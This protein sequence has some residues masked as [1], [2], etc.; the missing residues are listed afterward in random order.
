MTAP[1]PLP[2]RARDAACF[3]QGR[4]ALPA[5]L[6]VWRRSLGRMPVQ[7]VLVADPGSALATAW[8]RWPQAPV[9]LALTPR[10]A[11]LLDKP[12]SVARIEARLLAQLGADGRTPERTVL[13]V[14]MDW[15]LQAPSAMANGAIWGTVIARLLGAGV[16]SCLSLYH[17]RHLAERDLLAGLHAHASVV[18]ADG[19]VAN[20][21]QLPPGL[22]APGGSAQVARLRLDHWL[23]HLSPTLQP[24]EAVA[25]SAQAA[26][27]SGGEVS[28]ALPGAGDNG[29][30]DGDA[31]A[32]TGERW[33]IR[34]FGSLRVYRRDGQALQWQ[35]STGDG[36]SGA[37]RKLRGL[38]A[39]LLMAGDRG[40]SAAELV[41][42]L[43]PQADAPEKALNR[44]HHTINQLRQVLLPADEADE[45]ARSASTAA[46]PA[47]KARQ[48]PYLLRQDQRYV[49]RTPPNSWIDVEEF[50][51]LCRQGGDLLR[52][53][54]PQEALMCFDSA[55]T[56]Y[57]GD[58]FADLPAA[59]TDGTDADWCASTRVWL[60]ELYFKVHGDCARTQRELGNPLQ[61]AA[62][63]QQMLQQDP[64]S[65]FAHAE[66]MRLHAAQGRRDALERQFQRYRRALAAN[67]QGPGPGEAAPLPLMDLYVALMRD[68]TPVKT[69]RT[70]R[71]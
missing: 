51:Q 30:S 63:C 42:A 26:P 5:L 35:H 52:D 39:M 43:W 70:A 11:G 9:S 40:V 55:L 15:L 16:R 28:P 19:C 1:K 66:L 2:P 38:F 34:C 44:L 68:L 8:R 24:P 59:L 49:L 18:A 46:Q 13:L 3:L 65:D 67:D 57:T 54:R 20:P 41:D 31:A 6:P 4:D 61:A 62:H 29:D 27:L 71:R 48:H 36:R 32:A 53:G 58:L 17:R 21:Y 60:R 56:L 33:K 25:P 23:T 64:A 47:R 37:T 7:A 14:D 22:A 50:P 12:F 69:P 10:A 45:S